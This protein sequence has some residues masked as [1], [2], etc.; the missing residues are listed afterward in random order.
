MTRSTQSTLSRR[1]VLALAT[2]ASATLF[3][4]RP[5]AA[6]APMRVGAAEIR[7]VSDG[8]LVLPAAFV[9]PDTAEKDRNAALSANG[10]TG[11]MLKPDCN[12]TVLRSGDR[13][14]V[15]DAGSG[16]NFMPSAG[17]LVEGMNAAGLDPAAVTDVVF[18]HLHPDHFWG[19]T[20]EL[21]EIVFPKATYHVG[22]AEWDFWR[23][24][25]TLAKMPDDR[26]SFVVGAQ[27]RAP[28]IEAH[29]KLFKVG[30]EVVPGIEAVSTPGHTPGHTSFMIHGGEPFMVLGDAISNPV[31]FVN[32]GWH[33]GTDQ[34]PDRAA[35]TR[36]ALLGRLVAEKV[37]LVGFHLPEPGTGMAEASQGTFRFVQ[38]G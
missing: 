14:V 19:V 28:K 10:Q 8:N 16:P 25:D 34:E 1:N 4:G 7:V 31:S 30:A 15:F 20:D 3:A 26:K 23:G 18:T 35:Q 24:R 22:E 36:K 17:K 32:P 11:E 6:A 2:G 37:R 29:V 13:L 5:A 21:D 12:V 33:W 27:N 9:Y 38:I